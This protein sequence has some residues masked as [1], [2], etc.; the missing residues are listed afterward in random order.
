METLLTKILAAVLGLALL[1]VMVAAGLA[2]PPE[3][4]QPARHLYDRVMQEFQRQDYEAA[5]AGF[6]FFLELHGD[7]PLAGSAQY[8]VGECEFRLGRYRDAIAAFERVRARF[9]KSPK[10]AS[11]LLK[12]A[13]SH[14]RLGQTRASQALLNRVLVEFPDR[15]E[16]QLARQALQSPDFAATTVLTP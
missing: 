3:A 11:A 14:A 1:F 16:A 9:P 8:W 4:D 13:L 15:P 6:R 12:S 7:S 5:L 10:L 2:A